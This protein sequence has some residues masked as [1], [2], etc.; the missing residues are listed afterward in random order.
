MSIVSDLS[1]SRYV[2]ALA[3]KDE[4]ELYLLRFPRKRGEKNSGWVAFISLPSFPL[5]EKVNRNARTLLLL[6]PLPS[7][8]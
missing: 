8:L 1:L 3:Q 7:P 2:S 6:L 4:K 5:L